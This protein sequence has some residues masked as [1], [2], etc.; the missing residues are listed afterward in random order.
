MSNTRYL[1][2]CTNGTDLAALAAETLRES[3]GDDAPEELDISNFIEI[4]YHK[5]CPHGREIWGLNVDFPVDDRGV[6]E[7][8]VQAFTVILMGAGDAGVEH[9]VK[10]DDP[11]LSERFR[12]WGAEI[13]SLELRLREALTLIFVDLYQ[14]GYYDLLRHVSVSTIESVTE[15]QLQAS[16]QN[17]FFFLQFGN[18]L[19]VDRRQLPKNVASLID[20]VRTS[21]DHAELREALTPSILPEHHAEFVAEIRQSLDPVEK[22]RN[23]VAHNRSP[24]RRVEE[25][26]QQARQDLEEALTRF[27]EAHSP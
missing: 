10:F 15:E 2:L 1:C 12:E 11:V 3:L 19:D 9:L 8:A 14:E 4:T 22:M 17:E 24:S 26:Y 6:L 18:Y 21:T 27:F 7:Q 16:A 5:E 20:L 23:A 13:Y 25:N